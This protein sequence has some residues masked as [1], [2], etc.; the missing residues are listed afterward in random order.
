[1]T[2]AY[3]TGPTLPAPLASPPAV[4]DAAH[5]LEL[6]ASSVSPA[7]ADLRSMCRPR[8]PALGAVRGRLLTG[9]YGPQ[10]VYEL[11]AS[12][13]ALLRPR[14]GESD[15]CPCPCGGTRCKGALCELQARRALW[16]ARALAGLE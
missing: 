13:Y 1:M 16:Q 7:M 11:G 9:A 12:A 5:A 3:C 6:R 15:Q 4:D 14:R 10:P 2:S 8:A